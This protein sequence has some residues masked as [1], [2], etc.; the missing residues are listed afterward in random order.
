MHIP[1]CHHNNVC[2][3]SFDHGTQLLATCAEGSRNMCVWQLPMHTQAKAQSAYSSRTDKQRLRRKNRGRDQLQKQAEEQ[4]AMKKVQIAMSSSY[5]GNMFEE[6]D[7]SSATF[8][9]PRPIVTP[10]VLR[11][12]ALPNSV[13]SVKLTETD[14][15]QFLDDA[16]IAAGSEAMIAAAVAGG[17]G[18]TSL[19]NA[20]EETADV[21]PPKAVSAFLWAVDD[22]GVL[23]GWRR[24][25]K[26][27]AV[28][29]DAADGTAAAAGAAGFRCGEGGT[30]PV[31]S[32][33]ATCMYKSLQFQLPDLKD[34][35]LHLQGNELLDESQ[36]T[37]A[38]S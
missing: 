7:G 3:I 6:D 24:V 33:V 5:G 35:G 34:A 22:Q 31:D 18:S 32:I 15:E 28:G 2:S 19:P 30:G 16:S 29:A 27:D 9:R 14:T 17:G 26:D 8:K 4:Q 38:P 10:H 1:D 37:I 13:S 25:H 12:P 23:H 21:T 20:G 36:K 11:F